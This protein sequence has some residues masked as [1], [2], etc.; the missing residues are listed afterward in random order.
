MRTLCT[1]AVTTLLV[2]GV[3]GV[4]NA[5]ELIYPTKDGFATWAFEDNWPQKGDY[6]LNDLVVNYRIHL[7]TNE[8]GLATKAVIITR[9]VARGASLVSGFAIQLPPAAA[10][11]SS[12]R[13][14]EGCEDVTP[15]G[16]GEADGTFVFFASALDV[17]PTPSEDCKFTNTDPTCQSS[18]VSGTEMTLKV[19]FTNPVPA[20]VLASAVNP[21]IFRPE[22]SGKRREIHLAGFSWTT[23]AD[24]GFFGPAGGGDDGTVMGTPSSYYMTADHLPWGMDIPTE[25]VHPVEE[26]SILEAYSGFQYWVS[27][28]GEREKTWF[29]SAQGNQGG[30]GTVW[31]Y[32]QNVQGCDW[33][34]DVSCGSLC[35]GGGECSDGICAPVA[36]PLSDGTACG[37]FGTCQSAQCVCT[38][39]FTV[40]SN[41]L[42]AIAAVQQCESITGY[43]QLQYGG[44]TSDELSLPLL[45]NIGG[46]LNYFGTPTD[47]AFSSLD[48]PELETIG[49][50]LSFGGSGPLTA[51]NLP[52]LKTLTGTINGGGFSLETF[53]TPLL[54][55]VGGISLGGVTSPT[56]YFNF[57]LLTTVTGTLNFGGMNIDGFRAPLLTT[58]PGDFSFGGCTMSVID[59]PLLQTVGGNFVVSGMAGLQEVNFPLLK[60]IGGACNSGGNLEATKVLLGSLESCGRFAGFGNMPLLTELDLGKL[61]TVG[62]LASPFE[63]RDLTL[64][65]MP[66]S[67]VSLPKLETV[68]GTVNI[69]TFATAT[70]I[71]LPLLAQAASLQVMDNAGITALSLPT[72]A[73]LTE[74]TY[75]TVLAYNNAELVTLSLPNLSSVA[76]YLEVYNNPKIRT[77]GLSQTPSFTYL[78]AYN[79]P[80]LCV[81]D[82]LVAAQSDPTNPSVEIHDNGACPAPCVGN[83]SV[84]DDA[85]LA[86]IANCYEIEGNLEFY[87]GSEPYGPVVLPNLGKVS[88]HLSF[89]T[90]ANVSSISLPNLLVANTAQY[91]STSFSGSGLQSVSAPYL[92]TINNLNINS[93][94]GNLS[95]LDLSGLR[96]ATGNI[97]IQNTALTSVDLGELDT[98]KWLYFYNNT[99]LSNLDLSKLRVNTSDYIQIVGSP[100][101]T[102]LAMPELTTAYGIKLNNLGL[103]SLYVPKVEVLTG[104]ELNLE[105]MSSLVS[106]SFPELL[107]VSPTTGNL[108]FYLGNSPQLTTL[109]VPKYVYQAYSCPWKPWVSNPNPAFCFEYDYCSQTC[110]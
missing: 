49:G 77:L 21:F 27:S 37:L 67:S 34:R 97:S 10:N 28:G 7:E 15:Q 36:N 13:L 56:L 58:V 103:T 95:A 79:N 74:P 88:G 108:C 5:G 65:S 41:N 60:T 100:L 12:A 75:R 96:T 16:F 38:G 14:F 68:V 72:L 66:L 94:V 46:N 43:L 47:A 48:A 51:V 59:V 83:Y 110:P 70:V 87:A 104:C 64:A 101:L 76:S 20:A 62:L 33:C 89:N 90:G 57:P 35:S 22:D 98:F 61:R 3:A 4:A 19:E 105:Y 55:T 82:A 29:A 93:N 86:A 54:E 2:A 17:L 81:P 11:V 53:T 84:Y 92:G 109:S 80:Q 69:N 78:R 8:G 31:P 6:D 63:G 39:D 99:S 73:T 91:T 44:I 107:G 52:K 85:S 18:I 23:G 71:D 25:W 24:L 26:K 30:A 102:S 9:F 1:F 32:G 106:A 40:L 45:K 42:Q 50:S